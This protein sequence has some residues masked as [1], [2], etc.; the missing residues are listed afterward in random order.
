[1]ENLFQTDSIYLLSPISVLYDFSKKYFQRRMLIAMATST[2][3]IFIT[4]SF[5]I[6]FNCFIVN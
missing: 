1:M 3:Q 5:F 4:D 6:G 2:V